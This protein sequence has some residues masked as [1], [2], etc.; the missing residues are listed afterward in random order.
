MSCLTDKAGI[1]SF[2]EEK[3]D[4][5]ETRI[6][7]GQEAWAHSWPWQVSLQYS[8]LPACGGAILNLHWVVTA[9]HCFKR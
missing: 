8:D 7:G 6:I 1:R 2:I 9:S 5:E 4:E 3:E